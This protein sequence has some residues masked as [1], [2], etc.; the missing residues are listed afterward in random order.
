MGIVLAARHRDLGQPVA[1]KFLNAQFSQNPEVVARFKSYH[2]S[3]EE[4]GVVARDADVKT[5]VLTHLIPAGE[6]E[7]FR[8]RASRAFHGTVVVGKDLLVVKP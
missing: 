6:D 5:L 2:T 4:A 7:T 3:A 8:E 1:I